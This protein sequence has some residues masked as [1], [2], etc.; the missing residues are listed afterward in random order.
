M[1]ERETLKISEENWEMLF[2]ICARKIW[3]TNP[4]TGEQSRLGANWKAL[5]DQLSGYALREFDKE[6]MQVI[7]NELAE[8]AREAF[9]E[10]DE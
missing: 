4:E 7:I 1:K 5:R 9:E 6:V 8:A 2:D 3:V 10:K